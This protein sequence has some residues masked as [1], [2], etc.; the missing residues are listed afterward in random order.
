MVWKRTLLITMAAWISGCAVIAPRDVEPVAPPPVPPVAKP[1]VPPPPPLV[2][3]MLTFSSPL[4]AEPLAFDA[5]NTASCLPGEREALELGIR[6]VQPRAGVSETTG[7]IVELGGIGTSDC[8]PYKGAFIFDEPGK[9]PVRERWPDER[10]VVI[11]QIFYRNLQYMPYDFGKYQV[12]D[13]LRGVGAL[14]EAMPEIDRRRIYLV[15]ES[16]GGQLALQMLQVRPDLFAEVYAISG[17]TCI[18]TREE[19]ESRGYTGDANGRKSGWLSLIMPTFRDK[20]TPSMSDAEFARKTAE[21]LLR[22]PQAG[23]ARHTPLGPEAPSIFVAHGDADSTV[24]FQHFVDLRAVIEQAAGQPATVLDENTW[25]IDNWRFL[26]VPGGG[27]SLKGGPAG[28]TSRSEAILA[29][30]PEAFTRRQSTAPNES[31]HVCIPTQVDNWTYCFDG[32]E[33]NAV[34]V[35]TIQ[36]AGEGQVP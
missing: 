6:Y 22:S 24:L 16:G 12:V 25:K 1:P 29:M 9:D 14:L 4:T 33:L 5:D 34:T 18:P 23:L 3:Q 2:V 20:Q 15:G 8:P 36:L 31:T 26:Q 11:A 7:L 21:R 13:V 17:I 10:G 27:H 32:R 30:N 28:L 19:M 35:E